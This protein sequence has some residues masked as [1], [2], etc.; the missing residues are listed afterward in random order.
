[1]LR[2]IR[3]ALPICLISLLGLQ[4]LG[5]E[6]IGPAAL[7]PVAVSV[8]SCA[9]SEAVSTAGANE[10]TDL[11]QIQADVERGLED[12][13]ADSPD[14][15]II[16]GDIRPNM[17][18]SGQYRAERRYVAWTFGA[19]DRATIQ[20]SATAAGRPSTGF[21][22]LLM[23]RPSCNSAWRTVG[24]GQGILDQNLPTDGNYLIVVGSRNALSSSPK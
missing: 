4:T 1:M 21:A 14:T 19:E 5:L 2:W 6:T 24:R 17:P 20:I 8:A 9:G 3:S 7:V 16:L 13:K 18:V 15:P 22:L 11:D 10:E 23:W 12:G